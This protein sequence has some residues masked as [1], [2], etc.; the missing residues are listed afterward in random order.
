MK[1]QIKKALETYDKYAKI[2]ADYTY[3]KLMQ[4]Q[5]NKFISMLPKKGKIL[6]VGSGSGRDAQYFHDYGLD[7][8]SIDFSENMLKEAKKRVKGVKFIKMD[9][10]NLE[11]ENNSFDGIWVMASLSDIERKES[12]NIL[13]GISKILKKNGVVYIAVKEGTT[14][15]VV[16]KPQYNNSPRYYTFYTQAELEDKLKKSGFSVL[17]AQTSEDQGTKWVEIF[18]KKSS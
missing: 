3:S 8:T 14:E 16:S 17:N 11:F 4:F 2:Y 10:C 13:Q 1:E 15:E 18:A 12:L 7:V 5:L 9:M 6:D